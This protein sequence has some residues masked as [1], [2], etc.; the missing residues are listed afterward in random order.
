MAKELTTH[1]KLDTIMKQQETILSAI[2]ILYKSLFK[3][4]DSK[5]KIA[6]LLQDNQIL[7]A[8]IIKRNKAMD[9]QFKKKLNS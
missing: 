2:Q 8:D 9:A 6:E 4:D 1:Q 7:L 3:S 5:D